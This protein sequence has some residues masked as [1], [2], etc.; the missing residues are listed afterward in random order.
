VSP[1]LSL[2]VAPKRQIPV[3]WHGLSVVHAVI[4]RVPVHFRDKSPINLP[5]PDIPIKGLL[6]QMVK[7]AITEKDE[8][9]QVEVTCATMNEV[10]RREVRRK[11]AE[12]WKC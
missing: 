12:K 2:P 1:V 7:D 11:A 10:E 6:V 9:E 3:P 8:S 4:G 5:F